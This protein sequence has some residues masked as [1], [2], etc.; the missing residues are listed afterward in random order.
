[1][2]R[3]TERVEEENLNILDIIPVVIKR[4]KIV[5]LAL[6]LV[7]SALS[8]AIY[9][10]WQNQVPVYVSTTKITLGTNKLEVE[11]EE[12][13][14]VREK[15]DMDQEVSL[16]RSNIIAEQAAKTLKEKYGYEESSEKLMYDIRKALNRGQELEDAD[17]YIRETPGIVRG[18]KRLNQDENTIIISSTSENPQFSYDV[19]SA[20]L[21]GYLNEKREGE[22]KFFEDAHRTFNEQVTVAYQELLNAEKKLAEF[23]I[24]NE[25]VIYAVETYEMPS[26]EDKEVIASAVNEKHLSIK[27]EISEIEA[28]LRNANSL[29]ETNLLAAFS[30]II[31]EDE[32]TLTHI[33]K[34]KLI[35]KEEELNSL[36][37]VNEELHPSVIKIRGEIKALG[38]KIETEI[39][40]AISETGIKLN[41]VKKKE[42][43]LSRLI[44]AGLYEKLIEYSML[45]RAISVRRNAY[46]KLAEAL[47]KLDMGAKIERYTNIVIFEPHKVP[48]VSTKRL[49]NKDAAMAVLFAILAAIGVA[50]LIEMLDK[51]VKDVEQLEKL[52]EVPVL[53]TISDYGKGPGPKQ[54]IE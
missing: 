45:K 13:D 16:L 26:Q 17:M 47:Q 43:E 6:V 35:E 52:L 23:V 25:D 37:Q 15:Y 46:N 32:H 39:R 4:W 28:F 29:L 1:M 51:S 12:G 41:E 54:S 53:A 50:Y 19:I 7:F 22:R 10:R 18:N 33:L 49:P 31:R 2:A 11:T 21:E 40:N 42:K 20:V 5:L 24:K 48:K 30:L 44:E 3:E 34:D 27:R 8:Y 36:L 38:K 9:Y 14:I